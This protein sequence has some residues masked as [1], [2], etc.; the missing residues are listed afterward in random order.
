MTGIGLMKNIS[1]FSTP[2][3]HI[4]KKYARRRIA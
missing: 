4:L 1:P 3:R 2:H